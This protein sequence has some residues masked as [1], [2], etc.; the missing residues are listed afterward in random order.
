MLQKDILLVE[1][2]ATDRDLVLSSLGDLAPRIKWL[3]D[4]A[5]AQDYL[6]RIGKYSG[7][8]SR[9]PVRLIL[10]DL[11]LPKISGREL[12][13]LVKAD[14]RTRSIPV[15]VW[16][17]SG[18]EQSIAESYRSGANSFI[19]KPLDA[20]RLAAVIEHTVRYWTEINMTAEEL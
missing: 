20:G 9:K 1:D 4:G 7:H 16:S 19:I 18:D 15:V 3:P 10:L 8:D 14:Y 13:R 11:H 5:A 2:S 17:S 12:L 6:L